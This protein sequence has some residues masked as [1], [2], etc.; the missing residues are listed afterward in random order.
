[1][2]LNPAGDE[3]R[4]PSKR[5]NAVVENDKFGKFARRI[6]RAFA[7]RVGDG[8]VEAL[9]DMVALSSDLDDAIGVAVMGL[10]AYGYSWEEIGSRLGVSRQAAQQ[11][12]GATK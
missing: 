3:S 9:Q 5:R 6:I 12:W 10:R 11:R 7:K 4:P 1:M 8:D 2:T